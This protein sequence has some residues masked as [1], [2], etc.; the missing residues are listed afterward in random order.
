MD[1]ERRR[2]AD[3]AANK[4]FAKKFDDVKKRYADA[5]QVIRP[6]A[7]AIFKDQ[8]V[9]GVIKAVVN[10]SKVFLDLLY[11]LG[12]KPEDLKELVS[13]S[14]TSPGEALRKIIVT[15][16]LVVKELAK[17]TA[18][19]TETARGTDGKF[20]KETPAKE[21]KAPK[22]PAEPGGHGAPPGDEAAGAV[23]AGDFRAFRDA[24]NR[25]DLA[26]RKGQ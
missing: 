10:D 9:P 23:K 17:A 26:R 20:A 8:A 21:T 25:R 12:G 11:V 2:L 7:D 13:L 22:P 19:A 15:E 4:E 24:Q 1:K 18:E 14:K 3:E 6:A 5:D 16:D